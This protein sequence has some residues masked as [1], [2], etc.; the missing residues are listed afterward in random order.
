[1]CH[2]QNYLS[3]YFDGDI[4]GAIRQKIREHVEHCA[5][6]RKTLQEMQSLQTLL[7]TDPPPEH[8]KALKRFQDSLAYIQPRPNR[9]WRRRVNLPLPLATLAAVLFA[10]LGISL[11]IVSS[12]SQFRQ[13]SIKREP[14]GVTEIQ[15]AAPIEDLELL[16]KSLDA[17]GFK[18]EI[19]IT[20]PEET[21]FIIV[22]EPRMVREADYSAMATQW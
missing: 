6:C 2:E 20:L 16:L 9:L 17:N 3:A 21:R 12:H 11:A 22:G 8:R 1:M 4:E 18:Q 19:I 13:M 14:S 5:V 7:K 10:C 15:V